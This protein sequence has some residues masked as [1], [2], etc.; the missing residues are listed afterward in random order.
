MGAVQN[1]GQHLKGILG[2]IEA[3]LSNWVVGLPPDTIPIR[4]VQAVGLLMNITRRYLQ[5]TCDAQLDFE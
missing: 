2:T 3:H 1:F 5:E 4:S